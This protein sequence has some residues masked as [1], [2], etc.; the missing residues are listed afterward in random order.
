MTAER[1]WEDMTEKGMIHGRFQVFHLKHMEYVLAAKMR[2]RTLYIGITHPD[3]TAYPATS[4]LDE[5]GTTRMDNP[6]TYIERYEMIRGALEEFGVSRDEYEII[7][8]PV[9]SPDILPQYAPAGAVHYMS[10]CSPWDEE[11]YHLLES[12]DLN[13][14]V[15]W[16]RSK[17]EKGI[18]GT[19]LRA[20]IARGDDWQQYVP[21]AA[22]DYLVK[23]GIDQRIRHL[24]YTYA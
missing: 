18:T 8:F 10:I 16:R 20:M 2:C 19:S 4:P 17:E 13:V 15:L 21:K 7:P 24:Y 23:Y 5:H 6:L 14:E 12:M 9:S 22:A 3:I 1:E 11:K